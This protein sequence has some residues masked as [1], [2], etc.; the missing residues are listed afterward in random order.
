[1][2]YVN[3]GFYTLECYCYAAKCCV[4][5]RVE[6]VLCHVEKIQRMKQ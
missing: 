3:L 6:M 5:Q 4:F 2:K 1:M